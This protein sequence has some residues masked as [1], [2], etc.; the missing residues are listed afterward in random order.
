MGK[1]LKDNINS[2]YFEAANALLLFDHLLFG[3]VCPRPV[4]GNAGIEIIDANNHLV[5]TLTRIRHI[6]L[7]VRDDEYALAHS[8]EALL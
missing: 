8:V 1:R 4:L 5:L 3:L 7:A 2:Y 6:V